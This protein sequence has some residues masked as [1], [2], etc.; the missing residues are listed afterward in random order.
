MMSDK[1]Q[2]EEMAREMKTV[3][4]MGIRMYDGKIINSNSNEILAEHLYKAG[5]RKQ[6]EWISVEER[7]PETEGKYLVCTANGMV[8]IEWFIDDYCD[9][10]PSWGHY[11]V[12]HWMPLPEPPKG[13]EP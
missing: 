12:T 3:Q 1:K 5:C 9:G 4:S 7:L 2:I 6:S 13:E 11:A 10:H 8:Y